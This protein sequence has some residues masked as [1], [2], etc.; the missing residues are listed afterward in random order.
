M[1]L[2]CVSAGHSAGFPA[3]DGWERALTMAAWSESLLESWSPPHLMKSWESSAVLHPSR[4]LLPQLGG[5]ASLLSQ[6]RT[7]VSPVLPPR[8]L[9]KGQWQDSCEQD[10]CCWSKAWCRGIAMS[11][12]FSYFCACSLLCGGERCLF[13]SPLLTVEREYISVLGA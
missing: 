4:S 8:A 3:G 11:F 13:H 9:E 12:C 2:T 10:S 6:E 1:W 7:P 5:W